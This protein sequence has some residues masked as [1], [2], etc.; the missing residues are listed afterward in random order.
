MIQR[1]NFVCLCAAAPLGG[2]T[3]VWAQDIPTRTITLVV[4]FAAGGAADGAARLIARK[5]GENLGTTVVVDNKPGAGGNIAHQAVARGEPDGS[6]ILLGSI[7]PLS[8]AQHLQK[9]GYDP[10]KD[11]AP[12]TMGVMFPNVLVLPASLGVKTVAEFAALANKQPGKLTYASTGNGSASH[13][14]GELFAQMA[15]VDMVHIPYKGGAPALTDLLA[16]RVD[17]YFST[18]STAQAHID[19]GK[20]VPLATTGLVRPP[21]L[22]KLP[23]MVESGFAGFNA[24]NWY[25]FVAPGKT[26]TPLLVR[27]N[28]ELVKVLSAPDVK[29]E[30]LKHGLVAQPGSREELARVIEADSRVWG[31]L[32]R[33]RKITA[34]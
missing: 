32:I 21:F 16:G 1:R 29:D 13:L 27:W 9:L 18:L 22:D 34:D 31:K 4:G 12:L 33:E 23:T 15:G 11:L 5:L 28:Q 20:L 30:L 17:A 10:Q 8:I 2:S 6:T 26:A 24:V 7:G 25:A 14:A 3:A 19:S